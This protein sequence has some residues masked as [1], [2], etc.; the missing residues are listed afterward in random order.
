MFDRRWLL[1][2]DIGEVIKDAWK[3]NQQGS[4]LYKV[5]YKINQGRMH[6]LSCSKKLNMNSKKCI[7]Q[8]KGENKAVREN[9]LSGWKIKVAGLKRKLVDAYKR[10]EIYWSQKARV[11]WL[12][13]A[14]KNTSFFHASVMSRS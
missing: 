5:A 1:Q 13:E 11:Q 3:A 12:K 14:D 6:L 10:E 9:S 8:I 4:W 7:G 2:E